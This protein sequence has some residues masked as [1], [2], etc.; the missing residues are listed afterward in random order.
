MVSD[1]DSNIVGV[2]INVLKYK[3]FGC[4][5]YT[6]KLILQDALKIP[7]HVINSVKGV[8]RYFK[9]SSKWNRKTYCCS[10]KYGYGAKTLIQE[11]STKWN[12]TFYMLDRIVELKDA[13]KITIALINK[14]LL[15]LTE[16]GWKIWFRTYQ[17]EDVTRSISG[18]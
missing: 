7:Q 13:I 1:N 14:L 11:V 3:H 6:I 10:K 18:R 9:R 5:A 16:E 8:V 17:F 15:L 2:V 4:F 12:S